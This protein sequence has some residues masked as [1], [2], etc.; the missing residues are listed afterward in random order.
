VADD[1]AIEDVLSHYVETWRAGDMDG[2][3]ELF[4]DDS[5]FVTHAGIWWTSRHENVAE[6]KAVPDAVSEQKAHYRL[7]L[8]KTSLLSPDIALVHAI[9]RWPGFVQSPGDEPADRSGIV[10]MVMVKQGDRWLIRAS[11]NTRIS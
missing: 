7:D 10:S 4:T 11:H 2:W 8:A 1:T 5:D 9:W 3:G 6:H